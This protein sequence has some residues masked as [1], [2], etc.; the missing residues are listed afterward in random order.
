MFLEEAIRAHC[1]PPAVYFQQEAGPSQLPSVT[2]LDIRMF[3]PRIQENPFC[4]RCDIKR[5]LRVLEEEPSSE[6]S[7]YLGIDPDFLG[8]AAAQEESDVDMESDFSGP[9]LYKTACVI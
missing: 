5:S 9:L 2:A 4:A 6:E 8:G 3:V 7:E 1:D